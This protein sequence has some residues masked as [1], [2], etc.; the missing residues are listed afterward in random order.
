MAVKK[1]TA[2]LVG[3]HFIIRTDHQSLKF[4][5]ENQA[6]TPFQEKWVIKMMGYDYEVQYRKGCNNVVADVLSR[7]PEL[8]SLMNMGVSQVTTDLR[9][10][11]MA[12]WQRDERLLKLIKGKE[13]GSSRHA[14]YK[15]DGKILT[16]K[17]KL[18]VGNNLELRKEI[19]DL[20]HGRAFGG[21]SGAKPTIH[22]ITSIFY[23]KGLRRDVRNATERVNQ[24]LETYLRCMTGERPREWSDW[25]HLAEWWYN[26]SFHSAIQ[27][28]P[29]QAL[30]G[31]PP[32][33]HVPYV[34][35]DSLVAEV[36]RSLQ[37][38]EAALKM[39]R[40]HMKRA[41]D[42]MKS[43]ANKKRKEREFQVGDWVFLKLQPY[44]QQT[45]V[46]R[47]CQKLAPKWFGP[48]AVMSRVGK[49]A[50]RLQLP[51]G[52]RVHPVFHVSQLKK[53]V[54]CDQV[55]SDLPVVDP[56]GS[57]SKE[58]CRIIDRRLGRRGNRA[59]TEVLVEWSNSFPEDSTW[60]VLHLLKQ[61]Y[62]QF[63]T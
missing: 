29:Y 28:T 23:W 38:R 3:R 6:I 47:S 51:E 30:Y 57:I 54:G 20:F 11:V 42:R 41:Q 56:D 58:P 34:A 40:F 55:Q 32:P 4:L 46:S 35:G 7:K 43:Q 37:H 44:R 14:K 26:T 62:P 53:R 60:E 16:R 5:T 9:E 21:H 24:C 50:Y 52:S 17:G 27:V 13:E 33:I 45:V 31:Q 12:T 8:G 25:V 59:V 63:D 48:F 61:R 10:R 18:V 22:K 36:D 49:V 19:I 1:W 2:Y 39:L 15:W